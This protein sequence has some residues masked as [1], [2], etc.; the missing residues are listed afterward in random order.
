MQSYQ[1][2][3]SILIS[4]LPNSMTFV[5]PFKGFIRGTPAEA[6]LWCV[7]DLTQS[8]GIYWLALYVAILSRNM[9]AFSYVFCLAC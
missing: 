6:E 2:L 4:H 1:N 7:V 9:D 5:L 8:H 3:N